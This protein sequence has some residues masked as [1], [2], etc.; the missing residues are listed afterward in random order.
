MS[1]RQMRSGMNEALRRQITLSVPVRPCRFAELIALLLRRIPLE[2]NV[3]RTAPLSLT[4]LLLAGLLSGA[5]PSKEFRRTVP[6]T[7]NGRVELRS[8][9]GSARIMPWDRHEVEVVATIQARPE[10]LDP[11]A[12][13]RRTQIRFDATPDSVFIQTDFGDR[14][15]DGHWFGDD[16]APLVQYEIKVPRTVELTIEDN[17]S[18]IELGDLLG[19]LRL[20]TDRTSVHIASFNGALDV[21]AD[22]GSIRIG[23]LLLTGRGEFRTDRT[24]VDL[25]I[26]SAQGM[27][28]DLD[29]DRV[30]PDVD[31]GL[32]TGRISEERRHATYRG[33]IGRGGPTLR[34]SADRGSLR[35]RRV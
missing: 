22:R 7:A 28:L 3:S 17:R 6:L 26:S 4:C 27:T 21:E 30:S 5:T 35:L 1:T 9:R 20:H 2:V 18:E 11:E 29:L 33:S 12:S 13:V 25:G 15:S 10:S 34:Y 31:S 8:E 14:L 23:R 16:P 24:D 32:L 19:R